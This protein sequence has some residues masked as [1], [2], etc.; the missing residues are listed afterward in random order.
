MGHICLLYQL[1]NPLIILDQPLPKQ[2]FNSL[3]KARVTGHWE[4]KLR[5]KAAVLTSALNFKPKFSDQTASYL[6]ILW[7][8]SF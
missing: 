8:K 4:A 2:K 3:V 7:V 1:P 6:V 5:S